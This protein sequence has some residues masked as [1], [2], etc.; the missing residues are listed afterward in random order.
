VNS[1]SFRSAL[2]PDDTV[3]TFCRS[4]NIVSATTRAKRLNFQELFC[5]LINLTDDFAIDRIPKTQ[6]GVFQ[7]RVKIYCKSCSKTPMFVLNCDSVNLSFILNI[8]QYCPH[9]S[10]E[11]TRIQKIFPSVFKNS[12]AFEIDLLLRS[13]RI[14][15]QQLSKLFKLFGLLH[16]G[17]WRL[18]QNAGINKRYGPDPCLVS[19]LAAIILKVFTG[20]LIRQWKNFKNLPEDWLL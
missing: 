13:E 12:I 16:R 6:N 8:E 17:G 4:I 14:T 3:R 20:A 9:Q 2:P 11:V 15:L 18:I 5:F 7:A 1:V 10:W 19:H